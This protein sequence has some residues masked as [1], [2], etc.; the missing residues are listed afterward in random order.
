[1]QR[2]RSPARRIGVRGRLTAAS[3]E[4]EG[5]GVSARIGESAWQRARAG[6]THG[7][8]RGPRAEGIELFF[9]AIFENGCHLLV[10]GDRHRVSL[11]SIRVGA[12]DVA[13][14]LRGVKTA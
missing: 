12:V 4:I 7:D 8:L 11:G 3:K 9:R 14:E 13:D 6:L 2:V 1:M 10:G 5:V